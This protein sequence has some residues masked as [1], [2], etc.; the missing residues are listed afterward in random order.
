MRWAQP[1]VVVAV[2]A[3]GRTRPNAPTVVM[4]DADVGAVGALDGVDCVGE[5]GWTGQTNRESHKEMTWTGT[6]DCD[7]R[8]RLG[9][10]IPC[11]AR[12]DDDSTT[13]QLN[14]A[15]SARIYLV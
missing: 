11:S 7:E 9:N 6:T 14:D 3:A 1:A 5:L 8:R 2:V 4:T 13:T 15:E 10:R 12:A